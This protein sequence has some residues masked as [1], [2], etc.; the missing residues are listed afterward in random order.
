MIIAV[1]IVNSNK[2]NIAYIPFHQMTKFI[3]NVLAD[4]IPNFS[5][6]ISYEIY[7]IYH[8]F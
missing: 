5:F 4:K 1:L 3:A 6:V 2:L 7:D 8:I